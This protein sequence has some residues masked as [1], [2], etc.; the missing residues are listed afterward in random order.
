MEVIEDNTSV[1]L[2]ESELDTDS[3]D[4]EYIGMVIPADYG[5]SKPENL[6]RRYSDPESNDSDT[7]SEEGHF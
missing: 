7:G 6:S 4:E 2:H 1:E 5:E 3:S